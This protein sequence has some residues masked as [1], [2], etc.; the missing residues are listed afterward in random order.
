LR[1]CCCVVEEA[2]RPLS[3]SATTHSL[4]ASLEATVPLPVCGPWSWSWVCVGWGSGI[5]G[6]RWSV[7]PA[8]TAPP[9]CKAGRVSWAAERG[10][11]SSRLGPPDGACSACHALSI[12]RTARQPDHTQPDVDSPPRAQ[13]AAQA[14]AGLI[15]RITRTASG[16]RVPRA[17]CECLRILLQ[18]LSP[19]N[20]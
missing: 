17:A 19:G 12:R 7:G 8:Q 5:R 4:Q 10:P 1:R 15:G 13:G 20:L 16:P 14:F 18:Q 11:S 3:V 9:I 2:S 6:K